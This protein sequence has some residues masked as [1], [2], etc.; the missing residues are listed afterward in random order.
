MYRIINRCRR[1][2]TS[3]GPKIV[4]VMRLTTVLL[5]ACMQ[6]S[7]S[8]FGQQITINQKN[9]SLA[10]V[11]KAIRKQSQYDFF[12]D[13]RIIPKG[14]F[15]D[16]NLKN[17]DI[18]EALRSVLEGISLTYTIN[19][20]IVTI[21]RKTPAEA[22]DSGQVAELIEVRGKVVDENGKPMSGASVFERGS[23]SRTTTDEQGEFIL[24][25][26]ED[27]ATIFIAYVG[28]HPV[29]RAV[30]RD[31]GTI[32]MER[33]T[34]KLQE[35]EV[36]NTGYEKIDR[37]RSAGSF[38]KPDLKIMRNRTTS[39]NVLSR[40][41]G[42]IPGLSSG[43]GGQSGGMVIRGSTSINA[44]TEPL[45]VVDN[46]EVPNINYVNMQD[47]E[48]ITVLKDATS[49][50]IWGAKAA[51]GVIVITT[52]KGKAGE[53]LRVDYDG[54]YSFNGRPRRDYLP[55]WT[56]SGYINS[57]QEI[58]GLEAAGTTYAA[59]SALGLL[60]HK[61]VLWDQQRGLLTAGQAQSKLDSLSQLDNWSQLDDFF[62]RS[63]A[64]YN[65]TISVSGGGKVHS[66]Y[67]SLN[68]VG[69]RS[70]VPGERMNQFKINLRNDVNLGKRVKLYLN[71]DLTNIT[72]SSKG[73]GG[74]G[75]P[76]YQLY[77]DA[78]G[79][80]LN[81][82]YI[83]PW[84]VFVPPSETMRQDYQARSRVN[85]DYS[86]LL[87][88][89]RRS[90]RGNILAARLVGG[91]TIDILN[92]LKFTGTYGYNITSV[93]DREVLDE[94]N[95]IVRRDLMMYTS[96]P[97]VAS[98]PVYYLPQFGGRLNTTNSLDRGWTVRN[99]LSYA[100][101]FED[102]WLSVMAGQEATHHQGMNSIATYYGWD[103]QL[104]VSRPVDFAT[105]ATGFTGVA[106][107]TGTDGLAY[108]VG[109]GEGRASRRS[110]YF[111]TAG[112]T[113]LSKYTLNASWRIDQSNLFGLDKSAQNRPVY[114]IGGKWAL[115]WEAFMQGFTALNRLDVRFSYGITGNA[116]NVG[117]AASFDILESES[118]ANAVGGAGLILSVPAN[119]KLTW[120]RTRVYNAGV[121]FAFFNNRLRGSVDA[122]IKHT[123]DLIGTLFTS[124]LT[125]Y[126][127][128][129]GN[130]GDLQNKG[131]DL[132]LN[133]INIQTN[134]FQW[135]TS[136]VIGYNRN[137]LT[138]LN[139]NPPTTGP[140]M[141]AATMM[142]GRPLNLLYSY[143]YAGLNG[144]GDPLARRADG[145]LTS[146]P[147][148]TMP[149]DIVYSGLTQAPW[150]GG[151]SNN[152]QYKNFNLSVNIIYSLG[153]K[154]RDPLNGL[155]P[156]NPEFNDRWRKPGDDSR[157][158]IPRY[159]FL[160][161][162]NA[163]RYLWYYTYAH[164]RVLNASYAKIRDISLGYDL[165]RFVVKKVNAQAVTLRF[166]LSNLLI[167]TANDRFYDPENGVARSRP[168]QGTV[169]VGAHVSF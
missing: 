121:D 105:L 113:Y 57:Q 80:A 18:D 54:Y 78:A 41:E 132:L 44:A 70:N 123:S 90:Q 122:Y 152:F 114:S 36:F 68:H 14:K 159:V 145:S 162:E 52:R 115:G 22:A 11:L 63:A 116:P 48:D 40:L 104:Q 101:Q 117:Q 120:E 126:A 6:V 103:D 160:A 99:Q 58:F 53:A 166:N 59:A 2:S 29:E 97:T 46:V 35:V 133:A 164:T 139:I 84:G 167:W 19:G 155:D 154:M 38:S 143:H 8:G 20:K 169:S 168:A 1:Y 131:V 156:E 16:V 130:F 25:N 83:S 64:E 89:G 74:S 4:L 94:S 34:G 27:N 88:L 147:N 81:I 153:Y 163:T 125:G 76:R 151:L 12:Y 157:T 148:V 93:N 144:E 62:V 98:T 55:A 32:K 102:H 146:E 24:R 60:P 118:N 17:A 31:L 71:S 73:S 82:N 87:E 43:S 140:A 21:I 39:T 135:G 165:P 37:S 119:D 51:N 23:R 91:G 56:S 158:D 42:L 61:Q 112:Y 95:W 26:I 96:A 85:L 5:I 161:S 127:S 108:N 75:T 69:T 150:N 47:V 33:A 107:P 13:G 79:N 100:R 137:K 149:E 65:Q 50:S 66:F 128:V 111:A 136:L 106:G 110:S 129:T 134:D 15:I 77:R 92:G 124:P 141:V 86:P 3:P 7:A 45:V 67:G 30:A 10:S 49:V 142:V 28:Y 138:R 9:A 72:S 109:G